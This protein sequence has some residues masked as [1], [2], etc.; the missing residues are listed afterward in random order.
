[1]RARVIHGVRSTPALLKSLRTLRVAVLHPRDS[2]GEELISQLRRIGCQVQAFWPPTP[3]LPDDVDTVF[4]AVRPGTEAPDWGW[5]RGADAPIVIAI[6]NYENPTVI[7]TVLKIGAKGL[8]ASPVRSFGL[9]PAL[10]LAHQLGQQMRSLARQTRRLEEKLTGIRKT[11][12]AK[13]ILMRT[14]GLSETDAYRVIREQAMA[15]RATI[16]E[17]AS[18]IVNANDILTYK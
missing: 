2:D 16:E 1:M 12:E 18:A 8:I 7:D 17:I 5:L 3:N 14:R 10:V 13:S 9:L 4:L 15:K 11:S 6:V